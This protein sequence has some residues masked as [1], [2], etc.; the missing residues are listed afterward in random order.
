MMIMIY[1]DD[2]ERPFAPALC[3]GN[4]YLFCTG[5][6]RFTESKVALNHA[7]TALADRNMIFWNALG[8]L[9][10]VTTTPAFPPYIFL[11]IRFAKVLQGKQ[12]DCVR[13]EGSHGSFLC[14]SMILKL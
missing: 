14:I 3:L 1:H 8:W 11:L 9:Q 4:F 12:F 13:V 7:P 10:H 6:C 5:S 2:M